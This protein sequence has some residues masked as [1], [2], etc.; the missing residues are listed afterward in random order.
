MPVRLFIYGPGVLEGSRIGIGVLGSVGT[1][2][3]VGGSGVSVG[4]SGVSVGGSG[5]SVGVI[6]ISV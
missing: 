2:V 3:A 5:V 4:G 6:G 1:S